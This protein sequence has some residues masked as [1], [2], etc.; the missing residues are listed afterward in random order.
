[1]KVIE[2]IKKEHIVNAM[3]LRIYRAEKGWS[4]TK[5]AEKANVSRHT[6]SNIERNKY[7]F[8]RIETLIKLAMTLDKKLDDF[9]EN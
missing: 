6:I 5:L 9:L 1:M 2:N 4:I 8:I 3:K 7:K